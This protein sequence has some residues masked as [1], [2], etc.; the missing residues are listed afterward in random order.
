M[1]IKILVFPKSNPSNSFRH[2]LLVWDIDLG[3]FQERT[4]RGYPKI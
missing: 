2:S 4:N 3:M 1:N